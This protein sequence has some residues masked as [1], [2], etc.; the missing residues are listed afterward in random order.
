M[1]RH[2]PQILILI[3]LTLSATF[4]VVDA[5]TSND[6]G[7][8]RDYIS[9]N[10][11]L[12][13]RARELV[14]A[15]SSVKA[16]HSLEVAI[17]LH[18]E[19]VNLLNTATADR[20][21]SHIASVARKA[22]EVIMQTIAYARREAKLEESAIKA[23]ERASARLEQARRLRN[24]NDAP[25]E[26]ASR[27]V[28]EAHEQLV[29]SR[30]SLR[31][32]LFEV[33]L[34]LAISSEEFST[35][36]IRLM[37]RDSADI[38]ILEREI[39]KTERVLE[40]VGNRVG[41]DAND[42]VQRMYNEARDLQERA[43]QN[44]RSNQNT[45]ALELTQQARRLAMRAAK[46]HGGSA[47]NDNVDEALRLTDALLEEAIHIAREKAA[48]RLGKQI[49]RAEQ[50]QSDA[51]QQFAN[52]NFDQALKMTLRSREILK[53]ALDSIKS[54]LGRDDVEPALRGTDK[55]LSRLNEVLRDSDD[56]VAR[57]L[58]KRAQSKQKNAWEELKDGRYRAALA[59]TRVARK[60]A[61]QA[62]RQIGY[63]DN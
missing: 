59:N 47:N 58:F 29:R 63:D 8:L 21:F 39:M 7:Q 30:Q 33:S 2:I 54:D 6:L 9:R 55:L 16:R 26:A 37:K 15:T 51:K 28:E 20:D 3:C 24:D 25:D 13:Q 40:R 42:Q 41:S 4:G 46:I 45:V 1:K 35:R 43:K 19:S 60:L 22:R 18:Q 31:E 62:F 36:A 11:E 56:D 38:G 44:Y 12:L 53:D 49:D 52:N 61:N 17:K 32:Y 34:R 10:A 50:L 14:S 23:I 5:Q 48:D 57:D 27:L